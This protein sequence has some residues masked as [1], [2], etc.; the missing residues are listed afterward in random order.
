[1]EK[2]ISKIRFVVN[3]KVF[4]KDPESTSTGKKI[5]EYG[6]LV[7]DEIGFE[8]FTF[9]KLAARIECTE[10]TIYRYF[11]NKH[12]LLIYLLSWYWNWLEYNLVFKTNNISSP[13][14]RL[15]IA[16]EIIAD[17]ISREDPAFEHIN[18]IS[19]HNIVISESSKA[20][21]TKEIDRDNK[22]GYFSTYKSLCQRFTQLIKDINPSYPFAASLS[23][24]IIEGAH[25]QKFFA[26]HLPVLS[27]AKRDDNGTI[28]DFLTDMV[29][30]TISSSS[31][32]SK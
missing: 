31:P 7:I 30:K 11:E 4:L 8:S 13:N 14:Q 27:D 5:V 10:A 12:K 32:I 3:E 22:E 15:R 9:K 21:L 24:T 6:I 2:L 16:I 1:M 23:S 28:L 29:L 18:E 19:L 17:P 20:Y 26:Q 25:Q